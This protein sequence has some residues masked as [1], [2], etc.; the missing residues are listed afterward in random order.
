MLKSGTGQIK[1]NK[2]ITFLNNLGAPT[3]ILKSI[4]ITGRNELNVQYVL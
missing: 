1:N 3:Q 2:N 4:K